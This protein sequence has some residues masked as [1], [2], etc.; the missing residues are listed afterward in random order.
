MRIAILTFHRAYNCGAM[1]QAWALKTVLE[2]MGHSVEFPDCNRIGE[3][4]RWLY[5]T[6]V[7][8]GG[9]G[10]VRDVL[11]CLVVNGLSLGTEDLARRRYRAFRRQH[12]PSGPNAP[13]KFSLRYDLVIV[14][15]DQVWSP[16]IVG[17]QAPLFLGQGID[18]ALPMICY[19]VSVGDVK[20][21]DAALRRVAESLSRFSAISVRETLVRD[22]ISPFVDKDVQV[23]AD[24]TLLLDADDYREIA[25]QPDFREPYLYVYAIQATK[26]VVESARAVA[27]QLGLKTV[28]TPIGQYSRFHAPKGLTYGVSPERMVGY[29]RKASFVMTSS[30]HGTAL[31]LAHAKRFLSLRE[32][33]DDFESRPAAILN[34][35]GLSDRLVCP[36][37]A[38][39][40]MV[41]RLTSEVPRTAY[42]E[43]HRSKRESL[44]WLKTA[45]N[46]GFST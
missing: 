41:E 31:A 2:R 23:V 30:F 1:L 12:L 7:K 20:I 28:I 45:I 5:K 21:P 32:K 22:Q 10:W 34:R 38:P 29:I 25:L 8:L 37:I 9:V 35:L 39:T 46:G 42:E 44:D 13:E 6:H 14:G 11:A 36:E 16:D 40:E 24:P 17:D 19:A 4:N 18:K 26:F 27:K 15:S 3:A 33:K 43:L